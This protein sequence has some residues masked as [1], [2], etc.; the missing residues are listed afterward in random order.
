MQPKQVNK[1][2]QQS[3]ND[4]IIIIEDDSENV[5]A[6]S[7][8][9]SN[10]DSEPAENIDPQNRVT[11]SLDIK[12]VNFNLFIFKLKDRILSTGT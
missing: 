9:N 5:E 8:R 10:I 2:S 4:G 12:K 3:N 7:S 1:N 11:P 6:H